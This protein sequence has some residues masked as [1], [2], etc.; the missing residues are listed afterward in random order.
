MVRDRLNWDRTEGGEASQAAEKSEVRSGVQEDRGP[1]GPDLLAG[2]QQNL[3]TRVGWGQLT[4]ASPMPGVSCSSGSWL[5]PRIPWG[6]R[7]WVGA[8]PP[9][10]EPPSTFTTCVGTAA[11]SQHAAQSQSPQATILYSSLS[12]SPA[13]SCLF[14]WAK[15]R[16]VLGF[17]LEADWDTFLG[18]RRDCR[19]N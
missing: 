5:G 18:W 1:L 19:D 15:R 9:S 16:A 10:L 11:G 2:Q 8:C 12:P 3:V 4:D 17:F 14:L 7:A 13:T 6:T